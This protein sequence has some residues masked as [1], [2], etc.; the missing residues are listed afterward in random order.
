MFTAPLHRN[1]SYSIVAGVFVAAGI[2]LPSCCLAMDVYSNFIIPAFRR[3]ITLLWYSRLDSVS[4]LLEGRSI[5]YWKEISFTRKS[6]FIS[7][8]C[9][10]TRVSANEGFFCIV[11]NDFLLQ[12][13]NLFVKDEVTTFLAQV[14]GAGEFL[15]LVTCPRLGFTTFLRKIC[16]LPTTGRNRDRSF[17]RLFLSFEWTAKG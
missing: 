2:W 16:A 3:H 15:P 9:W 8:V 11:V 7:L 13:K 12:R 1:G 5:P 6:E 17:L 4:C 10:S 14:F